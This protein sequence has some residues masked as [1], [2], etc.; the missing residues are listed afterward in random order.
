M[1]D[2]SF[3]LATSAIQLKAIVPAFLFRQ[4]NESDIKLSHPSLGYAFEAKSLNQ[5]AAWSG[6]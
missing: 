1:L 2:R 5:H 4:F 3:M 6:Y